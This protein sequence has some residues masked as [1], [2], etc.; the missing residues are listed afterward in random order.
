MIVPLNG[1][2]GAVNGAGMARPLR[3]RL[4][5][6]GST[7]SVPGSSE[8][9]RHGV[10]RRESAPPTASSRAPEPPAVSFTSSSSSVGSSGVS[11]HSCDIMLAP[12]TPS[13][14]EWCILAK[15]ATRPP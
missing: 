1:V 13:T 11:V 2:R 4:I 8:A 9:S 15:T 14:V 12:V 7:P 5:Q 3:A 6:D 10:A